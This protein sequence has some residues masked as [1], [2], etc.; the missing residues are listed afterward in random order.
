MNRGKKMTPEAYELCKGTMFKKGNV[1][2]NHKPVGSERITRDGYIEVKIAE[3]NKW[4][5]KS[6]YLW[7]QITGERLT[8]DDKIVFLDHNTQNLCLDNIAKVK[9]SELSVLNRN[10]LIGANPDASKVGITIAR[11][12]IAKKSRR[13][14]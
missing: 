5:L 1:P 7:E 14:K 6:R 13:K 3:P 8:R 2:H 11:L 12:L 4:Q 9:A 10:H